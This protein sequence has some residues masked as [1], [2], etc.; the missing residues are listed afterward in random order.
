[1]VLCQ[2]QDLEDEEHGDE[3]V[4]DEVGLVVVAIPKCPQWPQVLIHRVHPVLQVPIEQSN[5]LI[6]VHAPLRSAMV[7]LQQSRK[8]K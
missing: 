1:M 8:P 7:K 6:E 4:A 2:Y 3:D 5:I